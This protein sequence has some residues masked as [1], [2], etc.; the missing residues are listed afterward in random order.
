[1]EKL[2]VGLLAALLVIAVTVTGCKFFSKKKEPKSFTSTVIHPD[3]SKNAVLYEVNVR[4]YTEEGT[5]KAFAGHLPRLKKLGVDVIWF[6]PTFPIG[7]VNR[8]GEL[9][10]YYSVRDFKGVNPEFGT[11]DDF[12]MVID[13]IHN[14][15]MH[16][17]MDWVPN[18][19]SWDNPLA[20]DHP[21]F[22]VHD[23][24]GKFTPPIGTDWTDVIQLDWKQK[25]LQ[26]YMID[27]MSFWVK[28]G[29]DGFRV[30]HPHN[31]PK[32]F[33]ER[34]R[35]ELDKIKPVFMLAEHEGPG[36]FME[37]GFDMNYAWEMHHL[38][39]SV[40]QGKDSALAM[41]KYFEK[42]LAVYPQNVYRLMF[43]TNHDENS[44]AGTI[45]T[46]F[47][48]SQKAF[49]TLIFTSRGVPLLYSGQESCLNKRLRF[50][51]RDTIVWDTCDMTGFYSDL[52]KMRKANVALWNGESGGPMTLINTGKDRKVFAFYRQ[53]GENRVIVLLNLSKKKVSFKAIMKNIDG[54][55]T[56]YFTGEKLNVPSKNTIELTPWAYKIF[57]N[58]EK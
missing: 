32:E 5:F 8:K 15:G 55:Y 2:P 40:A 22:Y 28:M 23:S 31:T 39:K 6:M 41:T 30:D 52:M 1:M 27:A 26:D 46:I 7:E 10:S 17:I 9:G 58:T 33:W 35:V 25:G 29:V 50:F 16:V 47:G 24:L 51:V 48:N 34:A 49:A 36:F 45:D 44:W 4:Q 53:K 14:L 18:H 54:E 43:L 42:E 56:E 13:S 11:M 19:S 20:S 3:W 21:E 57:I 37:K 12:K 38:M